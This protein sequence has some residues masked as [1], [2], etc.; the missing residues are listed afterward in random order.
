MPYQA[1]PQSDAPQRGSDAVQ[2]APKRRRPR[3]LAR[4][5]DLSRDSSGGG[6]RISSP[7]RT[8]PQNATSNQHSE[9]ADPPAT[10][11]RRPRKLNRR[12]TNASTDGG[13]PLSS[14]VEALKSRVREIEEQV[15]ELYSRPAAAPKLPRRRGRAK[16]GVGQDGQRGTGGTEGDSDTPVTREEELSRLNQVLLE[17]RREL[18]HHGAG[19][20]D[21]RSAR[22]S[23]N[24]SPRP[25]VTGT[26]GR[27]WCE[28]VIDEEEVEEIPRAEKPGDPSAQRDRSVTLS[29]TY[30][31][32]L[33][34]NL[35]MDDVRAIQNGVTSAGNIARSL[36]EANA[37][38]KATEQAAPRI[39]QA[40]GDG[41]K[42]SWSEWFGTY[43]S[44]IA[45]VLNNVE[46]QAVAESAWP[47]PQ[48]KEQERRK[49]SASSPKASASSSTPNPKV[50]PAAQS[51]S[52]AK[53]PIAAAGRPPLNSTLSDSQ[54]KIVEELMK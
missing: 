26:R 45:R 19:S 21:V 32:R 7:E 2:T 38:A 40:V 23:R 44:S 42:Q 8:E 43:S 20:D 39:T 24:N 13:V 1:P 50:R 4:E 46:H 49:S 9:Q 16:K 41:E 22:S 47:Y 52:S 37:R 18:R 48:A 12:D 33:P 31:V 34:S 14:E 27:K 3:K 53:A 10:A 5:P 11:R 6:V 28:P 51:R 15:R 25:V 35:S 17:A 29:G 54:S 30:Q 36:A